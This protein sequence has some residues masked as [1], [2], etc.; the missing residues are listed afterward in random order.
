ME[1]TLLIITTC[2]CV[3]TLSHI[4]N[5]RKGESNHT[6]RTDAEEDAKGQ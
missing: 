5:R 4:G 6:I 2:A 3:A 1:K